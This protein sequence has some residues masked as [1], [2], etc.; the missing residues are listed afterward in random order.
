MVRSIRLALG[1]LAI[2][3]ALPANATVYVSGRVLAKTTHAPVAG[4][5]VSLFPVDGFRPVDTGLT[6]QNGAFV[7][8]APSPGKYR[9]VVQIGAARTFQEVIDVP[10]GGIASLDITMLSDTPLKLRLIGPDGSPLQ[11]GPVDLWGSISWPGGGSRIPPV[12][13]RPGPDG[14]VS[15]TAPQSTPLDLV[16]QVIIAVRDAE[17]GCGRTH[18][19]GWTDETATVYLERGAS[20][21]GTVVNAAGKPVP[22]IG[23]RVMP[24]AASR[25]LWERRQNLAPAVPPGIQL[26]LSPQNTIT[27][28]TDENGRFKVPALFFGRYVVA[29]EIPGI[30]T[31]S[32]Q[33]DLTAP[34]SSIILSPGDRDWPPPGSSPFGRFRRGFPLRPNQLF[35]LDPGIRF[36]VPGPG[37]L[38]TPIF[39]GPPRPRSN[40]RPAPILGVRRLNVNPGS[41][42]DGGAVKEPAVRLA[43]QSDGD[44]SSKLGPDITDQS[45]RTSHHGPGPGLNIRPGRKTWPEAGGSRAER[46]PRPVSPE[47]I[48]FSPE[49][50]SA[51]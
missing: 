9:A 42:E 24:V 13:L 12:S 39:P 37:S 28:H 19:E 26:V 21:A 15:V 51:A 3:L 18:L 31:R 22:E 29:A 16:S 4:A 43:R 17:L 7:L 45:S 50:F 1:L 20:I 36:G 6:L 34:T 30:G 32:R 38:P 5:T 48:I 8:K 41:P 23:V 46:R 14:T 11:T 44:I 10:T 2:F 40:Q 35:E 33:V 49:G 25:I 47:I 27:A